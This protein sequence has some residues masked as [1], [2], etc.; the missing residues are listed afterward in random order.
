MSEENH[1]KS[2]VEVTGSFKKYKKKEVLEHCFEKVGKKERKKVI[3]WYLKQVGNTHKQRCF[4]DY[5]GNAINEVNYDYKIAVVAPSVARNGD[6][7]Y[8]NQQK[9]A[10]PM[11][12]IEAEEKAKA[13]NSELNSDLA[14]LYELYMYYAYKIAMGHWN[15][16][17]LCDDHTVDEDEEAKDSA[18]RIYKIVKYNE[19]YARLYNSQAGNVR[20]K[21]AVL[22]ESKSSES[23][24]GAPILVL[25]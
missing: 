13:F 3:E 21:F 18:Q 24:M 7:Y 4:L 10:V 5:V 1:R 19:Q 12:C 20:T 17:I 25:R 14:T 8:A 9:I 15:M 11:N 6:L 16:Q 2:E 22:S 23:I